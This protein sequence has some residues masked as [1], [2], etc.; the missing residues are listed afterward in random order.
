MADG[1]QNQGMIGLTHQAGKREAA[2]N[3]IDT[4]SKL[5]G[6]KKQEEAEEQKAVAQEQQYYDAIRVEADKLLSGDRKRINSKAVSI[7]SEI[8]KNIKLFGG[9]RKKFM[10][11]GG[12]AMIG[13]YK[14]KV[15]DSEEFQVYKENKVNMEKILDLK[16][17]NLGHLLTPQD[18]L[19]LKNYDDNGSGRITYSG[20]MNE[21][22]IPKD[23]LFDY[24]SDIGPSD[25]I[26]TGSNTMKLVSNFMLEYPNAE[27]PNP[28]TKDG[29]T[30]LRNYVIAKGYGGKGSD[31]TK[32]QL[33]AAQ[34][35]ARASA[36]GS[37]KTA[38]P[39]YIDSY[40]GNLNN[41]ISY[42]NPNG[43][44]VSEISNDTFELKKYIDSNLGNYFETQFDQKGFIPATFLSTLGDVASLG[45]SETEKHYKLRAA[46]KL[47]NSIQEK[48]FQLQNG[49]GVTIENGEIQNYE[50]NSNSMAFGGDGRP[51]ESRDS[52][53]YK[54]Q[55]AAIAWEMKDIHGKPAIVMNAVD[56]DGEF[57]E[58]R[59]AE[60][61]PTEEGQS[62]ATGKPVMVIMLQGKN[63][64]VYQKVEYGTPQ[65]QQELSTILKD[66][67]DLSSV[68]EE[69]I[70]DSTSL[71]SIRQEVQVINASKPNFDTNHDVFESDIFK[72]QSSAYNTE[73][74]GNSRN[75]LRKAYYLAKMDLAQGS[76]D[77]I[78]Q[79]VEKNDFQAQMEVLGIADKVTNPTI[80]DNQIIDLMLE[81]MGPEEKDHIIIAEK[82]RNYIQKIYTKR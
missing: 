41:I 12:M 39:N 69:Q 72:F 52:Q 37:T 19:A 60:L 4:L 14:N 51:I 53:D 58:E 22:E 45:L 15:L 63:G 2:R 7:Q 36:T 76:L 8:R 46:R 75:N 3:D 59:N 1:L 6:L 54:F 20:L 28:E 10:A 55:G 24:G 18:Q 73:P 81:A 31:K 79:Q 13:D 71:N 26:A 11:N 64:T 30:T 57:N 17:K 65:K 78:E 21:I 34:R 50:I 77:G 42:Q 35:K 27:P 49:T 23:S 43:V 5:Y 47:P 25:I 68:K 66:Q 38:K 80:N 48:L 61:Y 9:S 33:A 62:E 40:S 32:M 44:P 16:Q 29:V 74:E 82:I 67:D 56:D 70:V